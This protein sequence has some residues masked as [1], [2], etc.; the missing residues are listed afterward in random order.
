MHAA[1]DPVAQGVANAGAGLVQGIPVST[2]LSASSLNDSAGAK[3]PVASLTTGALVM[4]T[5]LF[6]G[7][8]FSYLPKAVLAAVASMAATSSR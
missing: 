3:T 1:T 7:P 2:S 4:L 5:L 8:L 6:L